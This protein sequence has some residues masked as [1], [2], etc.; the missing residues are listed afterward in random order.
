MLPSISRSS[1]NVR[2]SVKV[3]ESGRV[4]TK[5]LFFLVRAALI[6]FTLT[7]KLVRNGTT[8]GYSVTA[9]LKSDIRNAERET[10]ISFGLS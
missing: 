6:S 7:F 9:F 2:N 10:N 4:A 5:S 3:A 1:P 8:I